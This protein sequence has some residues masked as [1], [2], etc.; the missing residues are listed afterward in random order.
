MTSA[1][2]L[3]T[4][5]ATTSSPDPGAG[6]QGFD[7]ALSATNRDI[8]LAQAA[9]QGSL[10]EAQARA[11][12]RQ[13]AQ[14]YA[15][16]TERLLRQY[17][18]VIGALRALGVQNT[19][20]EASRASLNNELAAF[21]SVRDRAATVPVGQLGDLAASLNR[22][23]GSYT[24][25]F[26]GRQVN[27]AGALDNQLTTLS[28]GF[29]TL[30]ANAAQVGDTVTERMANHAQAEVNSRIAQLRAGEL[31]LDQIGDVSRRAVQLVGQMPAALQQRSTPT[32]AVPGGETWQLAGQEFTRLP[33]GELRPVGPAQGEARAGSWSELLPPVANLD[34]AQAA[35][36]GRADAAVIEANDLVNR[37]D[38][39]WNQR[40][41]QGWSQALDLFSGT[42][43]EQRFRRLQAEYAV[44]LGE[45]IN[46][47]NDLAAALARSDMDAVR[48]AQG[49]ACSTRPPRRWES[50]SRKPR[51]PAKPCRTDSS[52]RAWR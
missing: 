41:F 29:G 4:R 48:D 27:L 39:A 1:A 52:R 31:T 16:A 33:N 44:H 30:R 23:A 32:A 47:R 46:A 49:S 15:V 50:T 8:L 17:D 36:F 14:E 3:D 43:G 40:D 7:A 34:P 26:Q 9:P 21:R 2:L 25:N 38:Q 6:G 28:A 18:D 19:G 37:L 45:M 13:G 35:A 11:A 10:N 20:L 51:P 22:T 24:A 42:D 5:V 12:I